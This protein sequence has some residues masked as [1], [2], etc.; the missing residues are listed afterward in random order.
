MVWKVHV[1]GVQ[2][3]VAR[4]QQLQAV[5]AQLVHSMV[6]QA[7]CHLVNQGMLSHKFKKY[8]GNFDT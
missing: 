1:R 4:A 2:H 6:T 7:R 8:L 5:P 3:G